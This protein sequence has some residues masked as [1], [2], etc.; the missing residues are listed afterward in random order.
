MIDVKDNH[1]VPQKVWLLIQ[2][3][4]I[5]CLC[6][7]LAPGYAKVSQTWDFLLS[8]VW[9]ERWN[10]KATIATWSNAE[11]DVYK[12]ACGQKHKTVP[13]VGFLQERH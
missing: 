6:L 2:P 13:Q 4:S 7:R 5:M 3:F 11:T 8:M 12:V 10:C 1:S 9:R